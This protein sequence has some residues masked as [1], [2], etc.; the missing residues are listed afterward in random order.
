MLGRKRETNSSVPVTVQLP[1][2]VSAASIAAGYAH[3][4]ALSTTGDVYCWGY[5]SH[6]QV[7]NNTTTDALVPVK[8]VSNTGVELALG[9]YHSTLRTTSGSIYCW[10]DNAYLQCGFSVVSGDWKYPQGVAQGTGNLRVAA[11]AYHTCLVGSTGYAGCWGYNAY[12]QVGTSLPSSGVAD[13]TCGN[14]HTC[15]LTTAGAVL[16]WGY[17]GYGELGNGSTTNSSV[18]V[19]VVEP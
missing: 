18:P 15:A 14:A 8:V 9:D 11:G 13:I 7:G 12:G 3:T 10:G 16:C 2:G 6:Y 4:C 19:G 17:G 1:G 5:N